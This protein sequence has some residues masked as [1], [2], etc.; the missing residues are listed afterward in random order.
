M[1]FLGGVGAD[2]LNSLRWVHLELIYDQQP[3]THLKN[4]MHNIYLRRM[5]ISFA[6]ATQSKE[7]IWCNMG[8]KKNEAQ[9]S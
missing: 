6:L 4:K 7:S 2:N 5:Y 9:S 3:N 8:F 1:R